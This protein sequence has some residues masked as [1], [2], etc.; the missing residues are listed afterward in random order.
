MAREAVAEIEL[1]PSLV[2]KVF[3]ARPTAELVETVPAA[4]GV[5][6][7]APVDFVVGIDSTVVV[8]TAAASIGSVEVPVVGE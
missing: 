3:V 2:V 5:A 1:V 7:V 4:A 8:P 6:L